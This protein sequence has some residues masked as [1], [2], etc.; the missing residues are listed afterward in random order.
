[1]GGRRAG[2]GLRGQGGAELGRRMAG[3]PRSG[4]SE[5]AA[6]ARP[7]GRATRPSRR[8]AGEHGWADHPGHPRSGRAG[9]LLLQ[10]PAAAGAGDHRSAGGGGGDPGRRLHLGV[11]RCAHAAADPGL[12]GPGRLDDRGP[13]QAPLGGADPARRAL[14]RPGRR[15]AHPA[16]LR[17]RQGPGRGAAAQRG[18]PPQPDHAD[19]AD[20]LS[21]RPGAGAA[22]DPVG[23]GDRGDGRLPGALRRPGSGHRP[24]RPD[25]RPG[26]LPPGPAGRRPLP[27]RRRRHRGRRRRLH[28]D[29]RRGHRTG[30]PAPGSTHPRTRRHLRTSDPPTPSR[31]SLRVERHRPGTGPRREGRPSIR[32]SRGRRTG[33][34]PGGQPAEPRLP[35]RRVAC[36]AAGLLRGS[37][38]RG[39]RA[40]RPQRLRQDHPAAR[41]HGLPYPRVRFGDRLGARRL[42][43]SA[44][45]AHPGDS[46][47]QPAPRLP[48]RHRPGP[49]RSPGPRRRRRDRP[50]SL[51]RRRGRGRLGRRAPPDRRRPRPAARHPRPRPAAG[52]GRAHRRPGRRHRGN[53]PD[54]PAPPGRGD[55]GRH[56]PSRRPR[57]GRPR[58]HPARSPDPHREP[59]FSAQ[60]Q[61]SS[62]ALG[63]QGW[64]S[65]R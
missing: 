38:R 4:G 28:P 23:G 16:G 13:H 56:P 36:S 29:R 1:M 60:G 6:A 14:R 37:V 58:H 35:G 24:V 51:G 40:H 12:H 54:H 43:G 48:G 50:R 46:R 22:G 61:H 57:R 19:A 21:L 47:R 9:R 30:R 34:S 52:A 2:R 20:L 42:G 41:R 53:P 65:N 62:L 59:A 11:D 10:V 25:P 49:P 45:R 8:C 64:P 55:L 33:G 17:P 39:G 44:P 7:D 15:P 26:G 18:G 32:Q 27:R 3:G 31:A 63:S 5:V